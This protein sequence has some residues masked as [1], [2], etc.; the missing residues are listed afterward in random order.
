[1]QDKSKKKGAHP[2]C[3][4]ARKISRRGVW[5]F[6]LGSLMIPLMAKGNPGISTEPG[7][8]PGEDEEFETLLKSDGTVVKVRKSAVSSSKVVEKHLSNKSMLSWLRIK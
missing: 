8:S 5:P 4:E 2:D 7:D 6:L 1:M 3:S